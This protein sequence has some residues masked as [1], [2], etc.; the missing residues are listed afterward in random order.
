MDKRALHRA[1]QQ[2]PYGLFIVGSSTHAGVSTIIANW[3]TEVS[4]DPPLLALAIEADSKM[5]RTIEKAGFFSVNILPAG[6]KETAKAFARDPGNGSSAIA[7]RRFSLSSHGTPF[8]EDANACIECRVREVLATGDHVTFIGE[9]VETAT[10][11]EG[12][13]LTLKETGW[14][15]RR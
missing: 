14:K 12:E 8:L 15:Y 13:A 5:R 2:M 7:G 9:V 11:H 6:A 3:A 1:L 10:H 4:F